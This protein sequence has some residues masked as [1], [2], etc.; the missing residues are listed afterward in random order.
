MRREPQSH[1]NDVHSGVTVIETPPH[2]SV[3]YA[4]DVPDTGDD[5]IWVNTCAAY[6]ALPEPLKN[7][8]S[9]LYAVHDFA[10]AFRPDRFRPYGIEDKRDET[11]AVNPP[12]THPVVHTNPA[13]GRKALFVNTTFTS[14]LEGLS[15]PESDAILELFDAHIIRREL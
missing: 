4:E 15:R 11:Y 10:K 13:T 1:N 14:H 12:V 6:E 3:L 8:A 5:T 7:R 9:K 2:A